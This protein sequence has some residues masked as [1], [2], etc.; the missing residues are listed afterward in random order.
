MPRPG[1]KRTTTVFGMTETLTHIATRRSGTTLYRPCPGV[2][3]SVARRRTRRASRTGVHALHTRD[4][5]EPGRM[6]I[7]DR[8]FR[9]L[10]DS[11]T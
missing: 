2:A 6:P 4:A 10:A 3:W 1:R 8:G 11:T 7:R 9:W 5:V